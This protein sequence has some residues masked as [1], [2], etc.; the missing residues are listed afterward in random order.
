MFFQ[1]VPSTQKELQQIPKIPNKYEAFDILKYSDFTRSSL[2]NYL[3]EQY[4]RAYTKRLSCKDVF[5]KFLTAS[6]KR[7]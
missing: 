1:I 6:P 5:D 2:V 3:S 4:C 7:Q